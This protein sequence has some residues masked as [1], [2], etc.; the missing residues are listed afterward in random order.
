MGINKFNTEI[1]NF[2]LR[3]APNPTT[4]IINIKYD[5]DK[6][7]EVKL[8]VLNARGV[9]LQTQ[10]IANKTFGENT[11]ILDLSQLPNGLYLVRLQV[12]NQ[13]ET[14]KIIIHK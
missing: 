12:G 9:L 7:A 11:T 13:S 3:I 1:S 8:S 5:L 4:G 2:D 14:S 6:M 10:T